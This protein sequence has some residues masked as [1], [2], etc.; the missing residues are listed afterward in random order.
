MTTQFEF[1]RLVNRLTAGHA[2][3]NVMRWGFVMGTL[4]FQTNEGQADAIRRYCLSK[5]QAT[6]YDDRLRSMY[7]LDSQQSF[8]TW[9][10]YWF[11][12][13]S[14]EV[15]NWFRTA[16]AYLGALEKMIDP[17]SAPSV[18]PHMLGDT[19]MFAHISEAARKTFMLLNPKLEGG[20]FSLDDWSIEL[21]Q[22][23][24]TRPNVRWQV[25]SEAVMDQM[26]PGVWETFADAHGLFG[27]D[28]RYPREM[29]NAL[30]G[31]GSLL[32]EL[33][34]VL[35]GN[36]GQPDTNF[37][38]GLK[39]IK[40][41]R[42]FYASAFVELDRDNEYRGKADTT[43]E[44][45]PV[46][47]ELEFSADDHLVQGPNVAQE[48]WITGWENLQDG[49]SMDDM[50][51]VGGYFIW[52]DVRSAQT[53]RV[54]FDLREDPQGKYTPDMMRSSLTDAGSWPW[55]GERSFKTFQ[56]SEVHFEAVR[57]IVFRQG[58]PRGAFQEPA[59]V[60]RLEPAVAADPSDRKRRKQEA[61]TDPE[62]EG[63]VAKRQ[64]KEEVAKK[65]RF[66]PLPVAGEKDEEPDAADSTNVLPFVALAATLVLVA[67]GVAYTR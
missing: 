36:L 15:F 16:F 39:G 6:E 9:Y 40:T 65:A 43:W 55:S 33:Y 51:K 42:G 18:K 3:R 56:I 58:A 54:L 53:D 57:E 24:K 8:A 61:P 7:G 2:L 60:K 45:V 35:L 4:G 52:G 31:E 23:L 11:A 41:D 32:Y 21:M 29:L 17:K 10:M 26:M 64:Q 67:G 50:E 47:Y 19:A 59:D 30:V 38:A 46:A 44:W 22:E 37:Q 5:L 25:M 63:P 13:N 62:E 49:R 14:R 1:G 66:A 28:D 48:D 12:P 20:A 34:R 27:P